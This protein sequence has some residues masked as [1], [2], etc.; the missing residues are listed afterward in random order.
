MKTKITKITLKTLGIFH[1]FPLQILVKKGVWWPQT[2]CTQHVCFHQNNVENYGYMAHF[3]L[4]FSLSNMSSKRVFDGH[5]QC[6]GKSY[7]FAQKVSTHHDVSTKITLT[8]DSFKKKVT[9]IH[10]TKLQT[11][12][13]RVGK[14]NVAFN[15]V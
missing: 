9:S 7:V 4:F 6:G 5:K 1:I 14:K 2:M 15:I 10:S 3:L 12:H 11:K 8:R 13:Q